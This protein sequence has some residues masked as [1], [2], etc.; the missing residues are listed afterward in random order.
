MISDVSAITAY[1]ASG[2][3][4]HRAKYDE[5]GKRIHRHHQYDADGNR[6]HRKRRD[7]Q[8]DDQSNFN[9]SVISDVSAITAYDRNGNKLKKPKYDEDGKRIHRHHKYDADGNKVHRKRRDADDDEVSE[10]NASMISDISDVSA[11]FGKDGQRRGGYQ[12]RYDA[13]GNKIERH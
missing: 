11:L 5:N 7:A 2:K 3:K 10:F 4:L 9:A 8:A 12:P 13:N 6:I 1:D